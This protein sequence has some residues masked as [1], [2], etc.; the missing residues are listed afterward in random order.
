M[1]GLSLVSAALFLL[2]PLTEKYMEELRAKNAA[3][4]E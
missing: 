1:G 3:K 2:Y 4:A